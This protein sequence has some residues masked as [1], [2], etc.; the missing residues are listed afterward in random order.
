MRGVEVPETS[1]VTAGDGQVAY[2]VLGDGPID[3]VFSH[4]F[5]HI[6]LHWD[7]V[8]EA[9]FMRALASFSRLILFDRRGSGASDPVSHGHFPTWEE[10]NVDL[11]A[12]LDAVGSRS[13]AIYAEAEAGPR[14]MMFAAAHPERVDALVLS[15][16]A[17]RYARAPDYPIGFSPADIEAFVEMVQSAWGTTEGMTEWWPGLS[18]QPAELVALARLTRA[19]A[20]PRMAAAQYRH[21]FSELDARG[22]LPLIAAPTLVLV[23]ESQLQRDQSTGAPERARYLASS[24]AGA[25]YLE[26]PG[27]G[28]LAFAGDYAPTLDAVAEFL[29]GERP[30]SMAE[31]ILTTVVFTDIVS[32][33]ERAVAMG[34]QRWRG[35]LDA[36]DRAVREVIRHHRGREI[37][38]TGDGF[39]ACFDGPAR[40][41]DCAADITRAARD[42]D[43]SVTAGL[44]TG[45]CERRGD[46]IAGLAVHVA[47]RIAALAA[48]EEVLVSRTVAD[49]VIGSGITFEDRGVHTLKGVPG[50]WQ[51]YAANPR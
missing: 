13:A 25:R 51:L 41:I 9:S 27:D 39:L 4:G 36:H 17:A 1:Y 48:P 37:K 33:T 24:I 45:E 31:R 32:S 3:V 47:A 19:A 18:G 38:T 21:I 35:L 5:C 40:A 34:D 6:D 22:A 11:L 2:Q 49:L 28:A 44:H 20:T 23:N 43:L 30:A 10:W 7:V 42:L 8:S 29:T 16:T 15:N 12:V 26:L 50:T 14:A 46:D